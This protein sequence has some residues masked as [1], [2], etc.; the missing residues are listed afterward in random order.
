MVKDTNN[1]V[2][3]FLKDNM[4]VETKMLKEPCQNPYISIVKNLLFFF[5]IRQVVGWGMQ[6]AMTFLDDPMVKT[7][8][9]VHPIK[10]LSYGLCS[11]K[12]QLIFF[13][14]KS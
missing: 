1:S 14:E 11:K 12:V 9:R 4:F 8:Q 2:I 5:K 13:P 10:I 6:G 3:V 7:L